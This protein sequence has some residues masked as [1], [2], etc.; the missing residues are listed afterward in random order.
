VRLVEGLVRRGLVRLDA[1]V[2]DRRVRLAT[3]TAAGQD[4]LLR[5]PGSSELG[6]M[7]MVEGLTV[8]ERAELV[9]LL[10]QCTGNLSEDMKTMFGIEE[11][12]L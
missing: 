7:L 10:K 12:G 1:G 6:G 3:L 2:A 8:D 11:K 9:R 4:L 5:T